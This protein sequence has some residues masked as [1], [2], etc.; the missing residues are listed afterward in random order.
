M[1][2]TLYEVLILYRILCSYEKIRKTKRKSTSHNVIDL[3]RIQKQN[4]LGFEMFGAIFT[5]VIE[6]QEKIP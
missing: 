4:A 2:E 3:E 1:W 5:L 6:K